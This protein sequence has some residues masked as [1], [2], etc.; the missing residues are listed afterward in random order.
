MPMVAS[1]LLFFMM[2]ASSFV[3]TTTLTNIPVIACGFCVLV[4]VLTFSIILAGYTE[5]KKK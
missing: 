2:M 1:A 4:M 5:R 3:K